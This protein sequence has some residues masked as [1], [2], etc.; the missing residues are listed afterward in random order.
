MRPYWR[1]Q[2]PQEQS[3]SRLASATNLQA[4]GLLLE[5]SASGWFVPIAA[6]VDDRDKKPAKA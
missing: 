4:G 5:G 1:G 3:F 2:T 6:S